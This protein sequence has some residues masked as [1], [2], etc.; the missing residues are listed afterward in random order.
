M[1]RTGH[2]PQDLPEASRILAGAAEVCQANPE[3][4]SD[5][6]AAQVRTAALTALQLLMPDNWKAVPTFVYDNTDLS[7]DS[8]QRA[9]Y[10]LDVEPFSL[11]VQAWTQLY[12]HM[13]AAPPPLRAEDFSA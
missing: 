13:V 11:S 2:L 8:R 12:E 1:M 10:A 5:E 7:R 6:Q 4:L 9:E 3:G